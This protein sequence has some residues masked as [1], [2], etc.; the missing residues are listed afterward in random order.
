MTSVR[1]SH[2]TSNGVAEDNVAVLGDAKA[3]GRPFARGDAGVG[4]LARQRTARAGVPRCRARG[5]RGPSLRSSCSLEQKQSVRIAARQQLL[6]VRRVQV[7]P[8]GLT[9]RAASAPDVGPFVPIEAEPSQI[10]DD[11][12]FRFGRRPF[13][14]GVL[15]AQDECTASSHARATS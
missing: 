3:D 4:L 15:D 2:V 13:D 8:L 14:V 9:I 1:K 11:P 6:R 12:R 5:E 7:Q 10:A